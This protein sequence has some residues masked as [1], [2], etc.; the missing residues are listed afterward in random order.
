VSRVRSAAMNARKIEAGPL[1]A[2]LGAVVLLVSLFLDFYDPGLTAWRVFEFLDL[3][4][5]ALAI[6]AGLAA[7]SLA[8][9]PVPAIDARVLGYAALAALVIVIAT[10]LNHP[11]A[12]SDTADPALGLWLALAGSALMAVGALLSTARVHVTLNVENRRTR[13]AAVD[14]RRSA[15]AEPARPAEPG[16]P[17]EPV[18]PAETSRSGEPTEA[19]APLPKTDPE[20]EGE[21]PPEA[22]L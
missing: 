3:L 8:G 20:Q 4:L 16:R 21:P 19:T 18:G 14:A 5:A 7:A 6:T 9:A 22:K 1:I 2:L 10:L 12:V 13:V 17:A 15:A 11:P